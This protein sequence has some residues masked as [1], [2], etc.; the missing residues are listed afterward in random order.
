MIQ[1]EGFY[2]DVV[3]E[4]LPNDLED[5]VDLG[6]CVINQEKKVFFAVKN[7]SS[8][9]IKFQW[10]TQGC[11]DFNIIPRQG[12]LQG[13][14]STSLMLVFKSMKSVTHNKFNLLCETKRIKQ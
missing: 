13:N 3:F 7:N 9:P 8:E 10:N 12:H 6:N 5:E 2:E 14:S 11:E 4:N 1:G